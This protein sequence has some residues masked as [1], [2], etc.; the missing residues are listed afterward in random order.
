MIK[1]V[2]ICSPLGGNVEENIENAILFSIT[3]G[4]MNTGTAGC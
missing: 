2:Y 1:K 4:C 3:Q